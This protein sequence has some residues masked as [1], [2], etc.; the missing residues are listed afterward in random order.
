MMLQYFKIDLGKVLEPLHKMEKVLRVLG[1][2]KLPHKN[3]ISKE[4][5]RIPE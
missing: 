3:T 5:K 1:L 2:N 4:P